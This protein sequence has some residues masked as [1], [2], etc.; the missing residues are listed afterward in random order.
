MTAFKIHLPA[1]FTP[2]FVLLALFSLLVPGSGKAD[3]TPT[4]APFV[5]HFA[6]GRID[7][8]SG[9]IYGVGRAY[10]DANDNSPVKARKAADLMASANIVRLTTGIR[11]DDK[12]TLAALGHALT[13]LR[14]EAFLRDEKVENILVDAG[15]RPYFQATRVASIKGVSGLSAKLISALKELDMEWLPQETASPQDVHDNEDEPWLVLDARNLPTETKLHPALFPKIISEDGE[16]IYELSQ[17]E[18]DSL[19]K[20]GMVRYVL[21]DD[22]LAEQNTPMSSLPITLLDALDCLL[23]PPKAMAGEN[24]PRTKRCRYIVKEV[25]QATGLTQTTLMISAQDAKMVKQENRSSTILK[26]CRVIVVMSSPIGGI[27]G[28]IPAFFAQVSR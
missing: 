7:W 21:S 12:Q 22:N 18:L 5:E 20:Q 23:G 14:I 19:T 16:V 9:Q 11:L 13:T 17:V 2:V 28:R 24:E 25:R 26:K 3:N 15:K 8:D 1:M 6:T 4:F 27:E 10:L